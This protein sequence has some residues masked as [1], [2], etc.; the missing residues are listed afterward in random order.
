M[1]SGGR[2][3]LLFSSKSTFHPPVG[4]Q[5]PSYVCL[6]G[7]NCR[8]ANN[9][10]NDDLHSGEKG[11][12]T[13][14]SPNYMCCASLAAELVPYSIISHL[15]GRGGAKMQTIEEV[16]DLIAWVAEGAVQKIVGGLGMLRRKF[17]L[18]WRWHSALSASFC[19]VFFQ[20]VSV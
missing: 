11:P 7:S 1:Q 13:N 19:F 10:A 20:I 15:T 16:L 18:L 4:T 14:H 17:H 2:T 3:T 9:T 6:R 8:P 5:P 12:E